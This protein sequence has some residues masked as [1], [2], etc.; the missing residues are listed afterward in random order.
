V[1]HDAE[2][3]A[4]FE[5]GAGSRAHPHDAPLELLAGGFADAL[6]QPTGAVAFRAWSWLRSFVA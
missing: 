6:A 5:I 1:P 2:H 3:G 4:F